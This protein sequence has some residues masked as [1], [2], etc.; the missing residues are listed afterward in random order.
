[1]R[2]RVDFRRLNELSVRNSYQLLRMEDCLDSLGEAAVYPTLDCNSGYWQIPVAEGDR[3]KTYF[4]CHEVCFEF[5]GMPFGLCNAPATFHRTVEM[6]FSDYRW[7]T[8]LFSL[9]N[10]TEVYGGH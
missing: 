9:V 3:A 2:F 10:T 7:R 1:M 6:L 4:T 8:C 5:C